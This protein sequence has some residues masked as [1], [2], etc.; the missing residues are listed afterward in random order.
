MTT[1]GLLLRRGGAVGGS[2][3]RVH[4]LER[5]IGALMVCALLLMGGPA[6][7]WNSSD[8]TGALPRLAF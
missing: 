6:R 8:M 5:G 3:M 4:G 1:L 7:A 2:G